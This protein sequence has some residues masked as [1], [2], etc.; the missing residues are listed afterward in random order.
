MSM[1]CIALFVAFL[2]PISIFSQTFPTGALTAAIP[3]PS[4]T[5]SEITLS[6]VTAT[7]GVVM[8]PSLSLIGASCAFSTIGSQAGYDNAQFQ[9]DPQG[10]TSPMALQIRNPSPAINCPNTAIK[11]KLDFTTGT[12]IPVDLTFRLADVDNKFDSGRIYV[13]SGGV[14]IN[15]FYTLSISTAIR[16]F[17]GTNIQ[18]SGL[19]GSG[20]NLTFNGTSNTN[21]NPNSNWVR[22]SVYINTPANTT[23]DSI[24]YIRY[25]FS[26]LGPSASTTIGDFAWPSTILPITINNLTFNQKECRNLISGEVNNYE[27]TKN[28][29]LEKNID[30]NFNEVEIIHPIKNNFTFVDPQQQNGDYSYRVKILLKSGKIIYSKILKGKINCMQNK[31]ASIVQNPITQKSIPIELRFHNA[32]DGE[33]LIT[34]ATGKVVFALQNLKNI[35]TQFIDAKQWVSGLYFVLLKSKNYPSQTLTL[36][37]P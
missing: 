30:G 28:I 22:G 4:L 37:I 15:Y 24:I 13:Y 29:V 16:V 23:V 7:D 33:I 12:R 34:N 19:S 21:V 5:T 31:V 27:E 11:T 25:Y 3:G 35:N 26:N 17:D 20:S 10:P 6:S 8:V 1:R 14:A 18:I 2:F 32:F 36:L 9:P